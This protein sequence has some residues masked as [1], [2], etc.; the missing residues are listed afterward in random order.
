MSTPT[1]TTTPSPTPII[2]GSGVTTGN[3]YYTDC[4]GNFQEGSGGE[5]LV[6]LNYSLPFAGVVLLN[7]P[8]T[9]ICATQTST[10]TPT[11]T[12]TNTA[13]NTPTPTHT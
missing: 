6:I 12:P 5:Q 13:S 2:C 9:T 3:Y 10:P 1:P 8:A 7:T 4:C 11:V